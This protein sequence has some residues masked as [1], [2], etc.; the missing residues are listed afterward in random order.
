MINYNQL[1][2]NAVTVIKNEGRYRNFINVARQ[3]G[4]LPHAL[5]ISTNK[6]ITMWC[7]N[8]YLGMSQHPKVLKASIDAIIKMGA[9][10][11]GTRNIGGTNSPIVELEKEIAELHNKDSALVFTSG[12]I[13]N[14]ASLSTLARLLPNCVFFSDEENHASIIEGIRRSGAEKYI[15]KHNNVQHLEELISKVDINRPKIIVFESAYSMDG[16][17]SPMKEIC[18]LAKK[19]NA[20]TY[21]DE[22]HTVGL[23]GEKGSGMANK[24]GL[25]DEIDIIQG[26]L[27]KAFGVIGGYI[28]AKSEIIDA[29]RSYASGFIF[30]TS[31]PPSVTKAAIASIQHLKT[32][33]LER[34]KLQE[35]V[36]YT[37]QK[38][39]ELKVNIIE[40]DSHIIPILINDPV[41]AEKASQRLLQEFNIYLQHINYPTV[42]RGTERLRITPTPFHTNEMTDYFIHALKIVLSTLD[43][44]ESAA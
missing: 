27:A 2:T 40:N 23:Y 30:T 22:V 35:Q 8:D 3:I 18:N 24:L 31:L 32:H 1:F 36:N 42:K 4:T 11:G 15:F 9:G 33:D 37:K 29:I 34:K 12:Y 41:K 17:I 39:R 13:A 14:D 44:K 25:T 38:L 28:A 43:V 6:E 19:Y 20:L 7:T 21:L 26:T 10:S 16:I 5:N